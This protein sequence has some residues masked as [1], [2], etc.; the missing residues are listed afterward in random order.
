M[1]KKEL[2]N[3]GL[4]QKDVLEQAL[5]AV[6][7]A[8]QAGVA[9]TTLRRQVKDLVGHPEAFFGDE[10]WSGLARRW[11]AR[12]APDDGG[13]ARAFKSRDRP[14]PYRRWGS[15]IEP[16]AVQQIENACALPVAVAGA[17][18]PDAHV[19]YGLPIG[20]VLATRRSVIP[21][22]VGVDIACRVK[23]TVFDFP[24]GRLEGER[25]RLKKTLE[26][27]T[28]FGMGAA[29][30]GDPRR[31]HAVM[32]EDWSVSPV[33]QRLK[34][35]G[36][37]QLGTSGSGNHFVEFGE[38]EVPEPVRDARSQK[39]LEPGRYLAL[40]S[41]SGSRGVG[42]AVCDH[43]SRIA[44]A[45]HEDLPKQLRH[46]SW[47]ELASQEGQEYWRAMNLMGRYAA[48]NH[49]MIHKHLAKALG[50]EVLFDVENHHN[51]AWEE[52]HGGEKLIVHR[53][54]A[55]PAGRGVLGIIPGSMANPGLPGARQRPARLAR[56]GG[57][58]RR[59]ADEPQAGQGD[60]HLVGD[61]EAAAR[62]RGRADLGR[63]RRG[64]DG[65]PRHRPGDG[66]SGRP[67]G[68]GG[69]VLPA[70]R[71]DGAAGREGGGL[72]GAGRRTARSCG[73]AN[74]RWFRSGRAGTSSPPAA[75]SWRSPPA[76]GCATCR[77][78]PPTPGSGPFWCRSPRSAS[79]SS[80]SPSPWSAGASATRAAPASSS[81]PPSA[82]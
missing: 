69:A 34:D 14:A 6:A 75:P 5:Q 82:G 58:R 63:H 80:A 19:G 67:G 15:D 26:R 20:G 11:A 62:A 42:A 36:W 32:D 54:G 35:K 68:E 47:L 49:A 40:L 53:K 46:L 41:H 27:E 13:Q 66:R 65:L 17:L 70:D 29:F 25:D 64:A 60:L 43:Y 9:K 48:A 38:I 7:K 57:P 73:A 74:T 71:Q 2:I 10:I 18:M 22:A 61:P 52:E 28:R 23:M 12:K 51:F 56:F 3:L 45:R 79:A 37:S 8:E 1:K 59:P 24:P 30:H 55:T 4:G 31:Q 81:T 33:T 78:K 76:T 44:M 50:F 39:T 77:S 72:G 21:Y 16:E